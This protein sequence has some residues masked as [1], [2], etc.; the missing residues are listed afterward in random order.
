MYKK[1]EI[2]LQRPF[3]RREQS[4]EGEITNVMIAFPPIISVEVIKEV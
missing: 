4:L 2:S 3:S 1:M